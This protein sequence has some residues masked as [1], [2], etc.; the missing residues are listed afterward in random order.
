MWE[1]RRPKLPDATR[2]R[3]RGLATGYRISDCVPLVFALWAGKAE[4]FVSAFRR[5]RRLTWG[6]TW[7]AEELERE[8]GVV[9]KAGTSNL[10]V[11]GF[12]PLIA[13]DALLRELPLG[14]VRAATVRRT[15]EAVRRILAGDDDRLLVIVGLGLPVGC[16]FLDPTTPQ[17]IA[18]AVSWGAIGARTTESQVHRQLAS[19][20]SMPVGFKNGTDGSVDV[21]VDACHAA[22][23]AHVFFGVD[24]AGRAAV[25]STTG[26]PDVHIILRGGADGP[27][28]QAEHIAAAMRAV[29]DAGMPPLVMVDASHDNSRKDHERQAVV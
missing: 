18:D 29:S 15:R 1:P 28:Y 7:A 24:A 2:I 22:Q 11:A 25:V 10:R 6:G 5:I 20:L 16:E 17:Y 12:Q 3:V 8:T 21:A 27:N 26:N 19:G 9:S 14:E 23:G 4:T 13:P